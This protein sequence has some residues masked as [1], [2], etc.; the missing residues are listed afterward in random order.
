MLRIAYKI[1]SVTYISPYQ[2]S[3]ETIPRFETAHRPMI[4]HSSRFHVITRRRARIYHA[5]SRCFSIDDGP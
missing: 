3:L 1:P 2:I 4:N 5:T